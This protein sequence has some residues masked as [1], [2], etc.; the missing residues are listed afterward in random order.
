MILINTIVYPQLQ[1]TIFNSYLCTQLMKKLLLILFL[2]ITLGGNAQD[3]LVVMYHNI[4]N[5]PGVTPERADTLRKIMLYAKADVYVVNE[6]QSEVGAD[7][8]LDNSL[9]VFG[10]TNYQR[11]TFIDGTDT[12][13]M[14]YYNSD[15]LGF[16]SQQ[17]IGTAL[18][19]ISE[20][21]LYYKAPGLTAQTDTIYFHFFSC[22]LKAGSADF[23]LRNQ[24]ALQLKY[25]LNS[26][27]SEVENVFVGGDF[28][29][30]SGFESAC[31]TI[32]NSGSIE[33]FDPIN[34]DGNWS[35]NSSFSG[36]H[37]QSTAI[38]SVNGGAGGGMD[39]RFD[40]IFVSED[41]MNNENG[42]EYIDG[43]Y[44]ALGQDGNRFN[45]TILSPAN[46]SIPDSVANA[47]YWMSDHLPVL[48]TVKLDETADIQKA[49][50]LNVSIVY[51][52]LQQQLMIE[53]EVQGL[54][55]Y[56]YDVSGRLIMHK[57][58]SSSGKIHIPS[59]FK[60]GVYVW[61]IASKDSFVSDK[62]VVY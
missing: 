35:N 15:K 11:A 32:K 22:H 54:D 6:L 40:L 12:D 5:F 33:L 18:R 43:T 51:D 62:L 45:G 48:M 13:N 61:E 1:F 39:D 2:G 47:L 8:I 56:L 46:F 31:L 57:I 55:F 9:N 58:L 3:S 4:L 44:E 17:Q 53:V 20:Y 7:L 26:I 14:L 49:N 37:T 41:V 30:Y 21:V 27:S 34:M 38:A 25:Y 60:S 23:E 50:E 28:N 59:S 42:V 52:N 19:D 16:V 29:L 36:V 10:A 24:E